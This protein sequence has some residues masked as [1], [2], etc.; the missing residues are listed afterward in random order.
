MA[1]TTDDN[2]F[3]FGDVD[4]VVGVSRL[5]HPLGVT[6]ADDGMIYVADTYN[7]RIKQID[8]ATNTITTLAGAG[9]GGGFHDGSGTDA[10][11]DEPGGISV[12]GNRLFIA[13]TNNNA[14]RVLDL[15]TNRM[16]TI[17]FPNPETLQISDQPTVI[18]GN[19]AQGETLTLPEQTV[20]PGD[21][22]ITVRIVLPDGYK[23]NP[24]AP[25]RSEWN[26]S[27][28]AIDIPEAERAQR[29]DSAEFRLPVTLIAGSDRLYGIVTT[30]YCEAEN[31]S[32][33]Y[34]DE[35]NVEVP[36]TVSAEAGSS[37]IVVER[38]ITPPQVDVGG[39]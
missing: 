18:G 26:N 20:A 23:I 35:V 36:V 34:I 11:V 30:Y 37:D 9:E 33:C 12:A 7:S 38:T 1:G 8:P 14:I 29:F 2:L 5:Q 25:S 3:D 31:E 27:S 24:D 10:E 21:G 4:G 39:L 22:A 6:G 32:L 28:E 19:N 16:S 15:T 13:D 17:L